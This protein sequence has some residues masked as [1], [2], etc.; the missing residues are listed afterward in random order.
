MCYT[1]GSS[2]AGKGTEETKEMGRQADAEQW[3]ATS[4]VRTPP[5]VVSVELSTPKFL[6][7][8]S[9][10]TRCTSKLN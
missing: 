10:F 1:I 2:A 9:N 7:Y 3:Y 8:N 4:F 6:V 5:V